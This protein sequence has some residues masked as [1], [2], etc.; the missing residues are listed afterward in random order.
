MVASARA[1]TCSPKLKETAVSNI[2]K[3]GEPRTFSYISDLGLA[4]LDLAVERS[5]AAYLKLRKL[6]LL[7]S[8]E[9]RTFLG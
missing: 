6:T 9:V 7:A 5:I 2:G 8:R 4:V 3:R 1:I